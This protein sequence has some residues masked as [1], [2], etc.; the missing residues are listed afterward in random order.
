MKQVY[1]FFGISISILNLKELLWTQ[2]NE[3]TVAVWFSGPNVVLQPQRIYNKTNLQNLQRPGLKMMDCTMLTDAVCLGRP[4][5]W[6]VLL[7]R[8]VP[9]LHPLCG[10][11]SLQAQVLLANLPQGP[12]WLW[13]LSFRVSFTSLIMISCIICNQSVA[14]VTHFTNPV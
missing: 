8:G 6:G 11:C 4:V 3:L 5:S 9:V 13:R 7:L 1:N 12:L 10:M 14:F 2:Q